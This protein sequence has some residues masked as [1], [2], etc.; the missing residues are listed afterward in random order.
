VEHR[1]ELIDAV[2][3]QLASDTTQGWL[4]RFA[5][6][7]VPAST[8]RGLDA[9]LASDQV[10][11]LGSLHDIEDHPTAGPY[12]TVGAPFRLDDDALGPGG[13]APVL[14]ADTRAVLHELGYA[15]G[16]IDA[17]VAGSVVGS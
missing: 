11:A 7:G 16:E 5:A 2:E 13:P 15:D 17:L 8:P 9:L 4:A 1:D 12:R 3:A 6:V 14:G 10:A